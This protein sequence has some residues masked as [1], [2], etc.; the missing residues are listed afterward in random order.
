MTGA[1]VGVGLSN[2]IDKCLA[3]T[4]PNYAHKHTDMHKNFQALEDHKKDNRYDL[5]KE[6]KII[7]VSGESDQDGQTVVNKNQ[8]KYNHGLENDDD[9]KEN[10]ESEEIMQK[11]EEKTNIRATQK[12]KKNDKNS[13]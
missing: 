4:P 1:R 12:D 11:Y 3:V 10:V 6:E 5:K 7:D 2:K 9:R 8:G 13:C